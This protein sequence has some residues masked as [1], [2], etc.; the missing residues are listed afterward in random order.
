MLNSGVPIAQTGVASPYALGDVTVD[1][2]SSSV[3]TV[4]AIK[5]R[6][7]NVNGTGS[8]TSETSEKIQVWT[9]SPTFDEENI[10]VSDSLGAGHD[11]D[12]KRITGFGAAS[13]TPSFNSSTN[14]YTGNVWTGA[15]TIAGTSEAVVRWNTLQHFDT[16]L[17]SGYL[18]VG[19]DLNTSRSGAQYFTFAFRRTTMANF[20]VR[21]TGKV[22]GFF[23]AAPGTSIDSTSGTNGWIDGSTTY[24]GAGTPGSNT[25]AGGNG[26]NGCAFTSGDRIIDG[27]NYSNATF[28]MTLGDQNGTD[29]TGNNILVRI[30]L[31]DGDSLTALSIE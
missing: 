20:T 25:G 18:P 23:V 29:A 4:E 27:T 13:D 28:T 19:P 14:N 24:G 1:I 8:Y 17:S 15:Q 31:E 9:A 30:K 11:D 21:L 12:G 6:A 7:T 22:S 3:A 5:F 2:T 26:S 10:A 16:D